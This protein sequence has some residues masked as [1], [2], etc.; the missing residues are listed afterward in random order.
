MKISYQEIAP[1]PALSDIVD[2]IWIRE[3]DGSSMELSDMQT[4]L[5]LGTVEWIIQTK[6]E[7]IIGWYKD[8]KFVYP[9]NYFIGLMTTYANWKMFGQSKLIGI[10]IKPEGAIRLLGRPIAELSEGTVNAELLIKRQELSIL[11]RL[12]EMDNTVQQ[13]SLL[14]AFMHH[15]LDK[16]QQKESYFTEVFAQLRSLN[17]NFSTEQI[18]EKFFLSERQMQ[19]LYK[20]YLGVSPKTYERILR[21]SKAVDVIRADQHPNWAA[22]ASQL[23][24]SDQAHL[25]RDFKSYSGMTPTIF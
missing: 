2:R 22:M 20:N 7:P 21:F 24:Y 8:Q 19:R 5:P 6:G 17:S 16:F 1:S 15:H 25:I 9:G 23:G 3:S 12:M 18:A 4:C 13:I 14:E 11:D 10:R